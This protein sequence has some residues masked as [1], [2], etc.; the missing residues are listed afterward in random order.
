MPVA[1]KDPKNF[2]VVGTSVPRLDIPG[3]VFGSFTYMQDFRLPGML[4]ARVV[5]PPAIGAELQAVDEDSVAGIP[6]VVKVVR[7]KNFLAVVAETEWGAIKGA[8]KLKASWSSWEG[9]PE[10]AKLWEHVRATKVVTDEATGTVGNTAAAIAKEGI[11]RLEA[12]YDFAIQTHGSIGPSCAV[13]EISDGK[14]TV[15]TASQA[16]HICRSSWRR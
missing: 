3:K 4:H 15:W 8:A 2:K 10:P 14:L 6:G 12:T 9:L 5:R 13:A 11:K 1:T 7:E 16:T